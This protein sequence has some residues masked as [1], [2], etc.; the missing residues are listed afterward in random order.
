MNVCTFWVLNKKEWRAE[1]MS[2]I[3]WNHSVKYATTLTGIGYSMIWIYKQL[4]SRFIFSNL[5][6]HNKYMNIYTHIESLHLMRLSIVVFSDMPR[7]TARCVFETIS[8]RAVFLSLSLSLYLLKSFTFGPSACV[9][10]E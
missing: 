5:S 10:I 9:P 3:E 8:F 2:E 7:P 4:D 1:K 6:Q